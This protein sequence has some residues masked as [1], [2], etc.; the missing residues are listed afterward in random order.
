MSEIAADCLFRAAFCCSLMRKSRYLNHL[1]LIP[2]RLAREARA[3][4][5][6][7]EDIGLLSVRLPT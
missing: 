6:A 2:V 4:A 1:V 5:R 3:I 7:R